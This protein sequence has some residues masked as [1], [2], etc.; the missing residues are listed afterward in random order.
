MVNI[1]LKYKNWL[2]GTNVRTFI[3]IKVGNKVEVYKRKL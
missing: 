2:F 3:R 1:K